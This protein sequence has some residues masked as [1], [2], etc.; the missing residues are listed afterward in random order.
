MSQ[1]AAPPKIL[2]TSL[3]FEGWGKVLSAEVRTASGKLIRRQIAVNGQAA[4]VLPYNETTKNVLL[5]RLLRAPVLYACGDTSVL[6]VACG[7]MD[8]VDAGNAELCARREAFEELGVELTELEPV[9]TAWASPGASTE[10][11]HLFLAKYDDIHRTGRGGGNSHETEEITVE[12][13]SATEFWRIWRERQLEDWRAII[14]L[15]ELRIRR[16]D[17]FSE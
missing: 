9:T 4:A 16:P 10:R 11:F 15:T 12:E 5:V 2:S 14:L 17:L 1:E 7:R 13:M 3:L 8:H 6:E